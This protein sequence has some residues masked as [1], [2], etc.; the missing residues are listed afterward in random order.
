LL[1]SG[2]ARERGGLIAEEVALVRFLKA[3]A[4]K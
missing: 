1:N 3:V 2:R 4:K